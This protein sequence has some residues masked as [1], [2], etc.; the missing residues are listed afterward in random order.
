MGFVPGPFP[1]ITGTGVLLPTWRDSAA[2]TAETPRPADTCRRLR[3][4]SGT[5]EGETCPPRTRHPTGVETRQPTAEG[6]ASSSP[7]GAPDS[8][9]PLAL[10]AVQVAAPTWAA[11]A[12]NQLVLHILPRIQVIIPPSNRISPNVLNRTVNYEQGW[13]I[14]KCCLHLIDRE[15]AHY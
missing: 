9:E 5:T 4:V 11:V 14:F 12:N 13:S 2:E 15:R 7:L 6:A 8:P 1:P 10:L 3:G